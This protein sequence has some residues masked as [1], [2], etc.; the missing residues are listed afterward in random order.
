MIPLNT[1]FWLVLL[2]FAFIGA[3]RGW[4]RELLVTLAIISAHF[5][6]WLALNIIPFVKDYLHGRSALDHFYIFSTLFVVM[7]MFG[8][9]GPVM[10]PYLAGKARREK[11]QDL[12]LGFV[13]GAVNGYLLAGTIWGFMHFAGYNIWGI[14]PPDPG[15]PAYQFATNFLPYVWMSDT[16]LLILTGVTLIVV[17]VVLL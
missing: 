11:I 9:A 10:S 7:A 13:F 16:L 1:F 14:L 6:R 15:S 12:L 5:L 2:L 4:V 8:Y 3:L 17:L